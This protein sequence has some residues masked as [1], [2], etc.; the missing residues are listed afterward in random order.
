MVPYKKAVAYMTYMY[1]LNVEKRDNRTPWSLKSTPPTTILDP[2]KKT[3]I[4]HW[5][6]FGD[7]VL[8]HTYWADIQKKIIHV[9]KDACLGTVSSAEV[10]KNPRVPEQ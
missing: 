1:L 6:R 10:A 5:G 3:F 9:Y 2:Q 8:S 7:K 4:W